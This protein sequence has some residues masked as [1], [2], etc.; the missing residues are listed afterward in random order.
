M[1]DHRRCPLQRSDGNL[2]ASHLNGVSTMSLAHGSGR[3][4]LIFLC[5]ILATQVI[6]LGVIKS[7]AGGPC[8]CRMDLIVI[9]V[10]SDVKDLRA[11]VAIKG[12]LQA[13]G[14]V[15]DPKFDANSC[16]RI[17]L[18][19]DSAAHERACSYI[20]WVK[21]AVRLEEFVSAGVRVAR[22]AAAL[23]AATPPV[24][25]AGAWHSQSKAALPTAPPSAGA[26]VSDGVCLFLSVRACRPEMGVGS[27]ACHTDLAC[28]HV[29]R[30]V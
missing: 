24:L 12:V 2:H 25:L 7:D 1:R 18:L 8:V 13:P 9:N 5:V 10:F 29:G 14:F 21:R 19:C 17:E 27:S 4:L 3:Y 26:V 16:I 11:I 15:V 28:R 23:F 20:A 22:G 6:Q 30:V